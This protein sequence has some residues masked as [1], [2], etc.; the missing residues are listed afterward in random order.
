MP[1]T[2][3]MTQPPSLPEE[4]ILMPLN[5]QNGYFHQVPG[6]DRPKP[7]P[8]STTAIPTAMTSTRARWRSRTA[9]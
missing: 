5:E 8:C 7:T 1:D 2:T 4:L 3:V 9:S 6:G